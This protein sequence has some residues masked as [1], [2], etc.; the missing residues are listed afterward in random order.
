[1]KTNMKFFEN[2]LANWGDTSSNLI[3]IEAIIFIKEGKEEIDKKIEDTKGALASQGIIYGLKYGEIEKKYNLNENRMGNLLGDY[4]SNLV[5][6]NNIYKKV[7]KSLIDARIETTKELKKMLLTM[8]KLINDREI[9]KEK[10][11]DYHEY[12]VKIGKLT[13]EAKEA[14]QYGR[15]KEALELSAEIA[16]LKGSN[17][18][19]EYDNRINLFSG[20]VEIYN[21]I[22]RDCEEKMN[23]YY[24]ERREKFD[25]AVII[26]PI[27]ENALAIKKRRWDIW[28]K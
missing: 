1:M 3:N 6:L 12:E 25:K 26:K 17:P 18:L 24:E 2:L 9:L 4:K 20:Q 19:K 10:F 7:Y 16:E 28:N 15:Q 8:N 27:E 22:I 5:G 14:I 11:R 21:E 13:E 23:D